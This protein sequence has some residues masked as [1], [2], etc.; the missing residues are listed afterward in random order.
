MFAQESVKYL[1]QMESSEGLQPDPDKISAIKEFLR[2]ESLQEVSYFLGLAGYYRR[3]IKRFSQ[4]T[5]P[6]FAMQQKGVELKSALTCQSAFETLKQQLISAPA[7]VYL[8][9]EQPFLLATDASANG[10]ADV[11]SQMV[12]G[13]ERAVAHASR[14]LYKAEKIYATVE[15]ETL[16]NLWAVRVFR[17]YLYCHKF[18]VITDH[19]SLS[20][21]RTVREPTGRLARWILQ[22]SEYDFNIKYRAGKQHNYADSLS[23]HPH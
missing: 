22:L 10:L 8:T 17:P 2:S 14:A 11:L 3:F 5:V 18:E 21:L 15:K 6:P 19:F 13:Q 16:A 7:F 23:R 4:T 12:D 9:F 20:W 1:G